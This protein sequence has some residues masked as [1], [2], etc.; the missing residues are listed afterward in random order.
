M[1]FS[2]LSIYYVNQSG[3]SPLYLYV[4]VCWSC[5][6]SEGHRQFI[7]FFIATATAFM[8]RAEQ[9][10]TYVCLLFSVQLNRATMDDLTILEQKEA[11]WS[12]PSINQSVRQA[13]ECGT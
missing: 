6:A 3:V 4:T 1:G 5:F 12:I 13:E 10:T 2:L 9:S 8:D 7:H 11:F